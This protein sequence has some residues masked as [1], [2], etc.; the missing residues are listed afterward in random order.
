MK[1]MAIM[2]FS[3]LLVS[4]VAE[5]TEQRPVP[6]V[7]GID[8]TFY[9]GTLSRVGRL[10]APNEQTVGWAPGVYR[11]LSPG[12]TFVS[13]LG[14]ES[15]GSD[16]HYRDPRTTLEFEGLFH[17]H[18]KF[19]MT[20]AFQGPLNERGFGFFV[21]FEWIEF[22]GYDYSGSAGFGGGKFFTQEDDHV[23]GFLKLRGTVSVSRL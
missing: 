16:P 15:P 13:H 19:N 12:F 14:L 8:L 5:A 10:H 7:W 21:G 22:R 11:R 9:V 20:V 6:D 4:Q 1:T 18:E 3:G 2:L 17:L 23:A